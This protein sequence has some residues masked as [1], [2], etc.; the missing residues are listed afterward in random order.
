MI[1]TDGN[2]RRLSRGNRLGHDTGLALLNESEQRGDALFNLITATQINIIRATDRVTDVFLKGIKCFV[3]FTKQ[4]RL[5]RRL[6]VEQGDG[7][8]MTVSH[9]KNVIRV[10]DEI[11]S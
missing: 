1:R 2:R 10:P 7:V 8:H 9:A 4:K 6:W 5:L 3:K 11:R